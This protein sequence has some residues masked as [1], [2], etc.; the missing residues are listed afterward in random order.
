M[1]RS[2]LIRMPKKIYILKLVRN[3][4]GKYFKNES[5][6]AFLVHRVAIKLSF[7]ATTRA[8]SAVG[9]SLLL[10]QRSGTHCQTN[11][12]THR[13]R[14]T[15][16]VASLKHSCL[17]IIISVHSALVLLLMRYINLHL[18]TYLLYLLRD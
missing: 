13:Y 6:T 15:V 14:L 9:P 4:S 8:R 11:S 7:P 1:H 2:F 3:G 18:L 10:A 5:G 16:S 17:Q 12:V